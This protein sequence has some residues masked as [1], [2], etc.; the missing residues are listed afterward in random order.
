MSAPQLDKK[1]RGDVCLTVM[2]A[3]RS[4]RGALTA[5]K[6]AGDDGEL[7]DEA[8]EVVERLRAAG[9]LDLAVRK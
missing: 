2:Q 7:F 6:P 8:Y 5:G 3:L 4:H 9:Y 1:K